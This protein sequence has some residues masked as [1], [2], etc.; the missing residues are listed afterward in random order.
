MGDKSRIRRSKASTPFFESGEPGSQLGDSR[1]SAEPGRGRQ[2]GDRCSTGDK[3]RLM[4][5]RAPGQPGDKCGRKGGDKCRIMWPR[6]PRVRNK[7]E[8]S[9]VQTQNH[10]AQSIHRQVGYKCRIMRPRASTAY[11]ETVGDKGNKFRFR[12]PRPP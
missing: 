1:S 12:W 6:A 4:R 11:L 7:W 2:L 10:A 8:T 9:G 3:R 5:P